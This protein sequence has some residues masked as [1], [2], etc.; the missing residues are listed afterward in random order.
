MRETFGTLIKAGQ[1]YCVDDSTAS[2]TG[3]S[4]TKTFLKREINIAC[5]II[6][7]KLKIYKNEKSYTD[8]TEEDEQYYPM[9][10]DMGTILSC[11]HTTGGVA[12]VLETVNSLKQWEYLNKK[13]FGESVMPQFIFPRRDDFGIWPTPA[14]ADETITLTY[15][16]TYKDMSADDYSAGTVAMTISDATVTGTDTV[17]TAVM[18]D[19][20]FRTDDDRTWYKIETYTSATALEL[21]TVFEGLTDASSSYLIGES[22]EIPSELHHLPAH[23]AT[24]MFMAGPQRNKADAQA[25]LNFFWTGDYS[26]SSRVPSRA[27]GG[28]LGALGTYKAIGR[29]SSRLVRKKQHTYSRFNEWGTTLE[30]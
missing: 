16:P 2:T 4:D 17:F 5:R 12:Y 6:F 22:P 8:L 24:G 1:D 30:I 21:E 26:N 14:T 3:L 25:E 15:H 20:W 13:D 23:Y 19:R 29:D 27:S 10:R 11:T 7:N 28:L 9:P 18:A